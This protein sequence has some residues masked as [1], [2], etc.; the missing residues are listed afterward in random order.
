M[1]LWPSTYSA[2]TS[3]ITQGAEYLFGLKVSASHQIV[4][5]LENLTFDNGIDALEIS[6]RNYTGKFPSGKRAVQTISGTGFRFIYDSTDDA[7]EY[8]FDEM[9]AALKAKTI[10]EFRLGTTATG[11]KFEEGKGFFSK[12]TLT[13]NQN[14][15]G[16]YDFTFELT[17]VSNTVTAANS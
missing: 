1:A 8:S 16:K 15:P 4:G 17:E 5:C 14:D 13:A 9:L 10:L 6:C 11:D 2:R 3:K 12:L 7:T